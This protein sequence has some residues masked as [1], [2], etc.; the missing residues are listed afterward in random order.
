M[1]TVQI[2][3]ERHEIHNSSAAI[4]GRQYCAGWQVVSCP[5][6][7]VFS[8]LYATVAHSYLRLSHTLIPNCH[9]DMLQLCASCAMAVTVSL[10][11]PG[12]GAAD[13]SRKKRL[14]LALGVAEP[15]ES[16]GVKDRTSAEWQG[17][18]AGTVLCSAVLSS[19]E[20]GSHSAY[21]VLGVA[22]R[23]QVR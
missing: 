21:S 6:P 1:D 15:G 4:D 18:P 10:A 13:S 17:H 23:L 12:C 11:H 8:W 7:F 9:L 3:L 2:V 20:Q 19:Q 22:G 14:Q 5:L 16:R